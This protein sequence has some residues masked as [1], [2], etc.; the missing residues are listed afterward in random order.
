MKAAEGIEVTFFIPSAYGPI[1][2]ELLTYMQRDGYL[3]KWD[4]LLGK[5]DIS[6]TKVSFPE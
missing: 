3:G 4:I 6:E 1:A 5:S 2:C